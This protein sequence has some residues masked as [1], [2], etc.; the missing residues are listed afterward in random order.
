[1]PLIR[2]E[3]VV[4]SNPTSGSIWKPKAYEEKKRWLSDVSVTEKSLNYSKP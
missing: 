1:M 2:N 4:G 3:Q